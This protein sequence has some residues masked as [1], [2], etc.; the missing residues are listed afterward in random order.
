MAALLGGFVSLILG[1][2]GIIVWWGFFIK[3]LL[4]AV[5]AMLILGGALAA[6]LGFEELRDKRA[7]ENFDDS[8]DLK[9]EVES[10]KA[11]VEELKTKPDET[12]AGENS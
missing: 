7:A 1:V 2:I 11:E 10:L 6:Y 3:A 12:G 4:A 5:P 9:Q 8:N